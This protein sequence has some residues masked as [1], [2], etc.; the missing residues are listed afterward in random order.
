MPNCGGDGLVAVRRVHQAE[1]RSGATEVADRDDA[2][3]GYT[4]IG[5]QRVQRGRG[6]GQQDQST[7]RPFRHPAQRDPGRVDRGR[8]PVRGVG[9]GDRLRKRASV[10]GGVRQR[11]QGIGEQGFAA[12]RGVVGGLDAGRITHPVDE[13]GDHQPRLVELGVLRRHAH[14]GWALPIQRQHRLAGHRPFGGHRGQVGG[15]HREAQ[16][17]L[18]SVSHVVPLCAL[19]TNLSAVPVRPA[20]YRRLTDRAHSGDQREIQRRDPARR[21]VVDGGDCVQ[22]P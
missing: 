20:S 1:C 21:E 11:P 3:F 5:V 2:A 15:P 22:C 8:V 10:G 16:R 18:F 19:G 13:V 9:D 14:L 17:R 7:A 6:V 4:G 12:M